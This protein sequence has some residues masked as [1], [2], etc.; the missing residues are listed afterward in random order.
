MGKGGE[1]RDVEERKRLGK[2]NGH[3]CVQKDR[4]N[5]DHI[6]ER[7]IWGRL[8][9]YGDFEARWLIPRRPRGPKGFPEGPAV[10]GMRT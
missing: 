3:V 5:T 10:V 2:E 6:G 8:C 1:R 4:G 9:V 7:S